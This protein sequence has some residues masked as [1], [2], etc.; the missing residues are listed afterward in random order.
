MILFSIGRSRGGSTE[1]WYLDSLQPSHKDDLLT[2]TQATIAMVLICVFSV[3]G[4]RR[5]FYE[6]FLGLH[7]A[8]SIA[9]LVGMW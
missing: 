2:P 5:S 4:L 8:I 3:Y 7:I 9:V 6:L 1:N